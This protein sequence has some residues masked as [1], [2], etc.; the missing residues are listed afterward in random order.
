[1]ARVYYNKKELLG[2]PL[3]SDVVTVALLHEILTMADPARNQY[4]QFELPGAGEGLFK[5]AILWKGDFYYKYNGQDIYL[6]DAI[7]LGDDFALPYPDEYYFV[8]RIGDQL[9]VRKVEAGEGFTWDQTIDASIPYPADEAFFN[10]LEYSFLKLQHQVQEVIKHDE[11]IKSELRSIDKVKI[12]A[13]TTLATLCEW[14]ANECAHLGNFLAAQKVADDDPYTLLGI[15]E[16]YCYEEGQ[17]RKLLFMYFD[18]KEVIKEFVW[19]LEHIL[20]SN[21]GITDPIPTGRFTMESQIYENGVQVHFDRFLRTHDLQ[22]TNVKTDGDD[23][24]F[25]VHRTAYYK[26][27]NRNFNILGWGTAKAQSY[28]WI[29]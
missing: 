15:I 13:C 27:I 24:L 28:G 6:P 2:N 10:K 21:Y 29:I 14:E 25:V 26:A 7:I 17:N 22:L 4:K 19:K 8:A 16:D 20:K 9:D 23:Y 5:T 3:Q 12:Q 11:Q 1:M 18:W